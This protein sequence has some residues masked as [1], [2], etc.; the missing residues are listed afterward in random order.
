MSWL[1]PWKTAVESP[2]GW[3]VI[4]G[5]SGVQRVRFEDRRP[6]QGPD[7]IGA[8]QAVRRYLSGEL[9]A[10]DE[11]P[12]EPA[13]TEYQ[14]RVWAVVR[15][16]PPGHTRSYGEIARQ[17]RSVARAVGRANATN[18]VSLFVPCHRVLGQHGK[19]T[20]YAFGVHRKR[21]L[22]EHE[23]AELEL[24]PRSRSPGEI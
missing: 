16:I 8:G 23:S 24:Y 4:E 11:V 5:R 7:P 15:S 18:P 2:I 3:V 9:R 12:I 1:F 6:E 14:R 13:G 22:L 17:L 21:W 10:L 20:G 19:L